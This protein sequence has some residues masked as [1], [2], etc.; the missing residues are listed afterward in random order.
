MI[1]QESTS[2]RET[3]MTIDKA[4]APGANYGSP[5][6][7][8]VGP[9]RTFEISLTEPSDPSSLG[10]GEKTDP[11]LADFR[12]LRF[13]SAAPQGKPSFPE[14]PEAL[15]GTDAKKAESHEE[16]SPKKGLFSKLADSSAAHLLEKAVALGSMVAALA[17]CA[18]IPNQY[19]GIDVVPLPP[20]TYCAPFQCTPGVY[21]PPPPFIG[22][23]AV[24]VPPPIFIPPP[25]HP[26]HPPGFGPGFGQR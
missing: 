5:L 24:V 20:T 8:K 13:D 10:S 22:P 23:P 17:G 19:G 2:R 9:A 15:K 6:S 11:T 3:Q 12:K 21:V 26:I 4:T 14:L 1:G 16:S 7:G 25:M 18:M